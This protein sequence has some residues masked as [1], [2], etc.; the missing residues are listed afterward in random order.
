MLESMA[1]REPG[2]A[3]VTLPT[4]TAAAAQPQPSA[5]A[6][7][8]T[9][10]MKPA[11]AAAQLGQDARFEITA[12]GVKDLYGAIM[13]LSYDPRVVE[14]KTASEGTLLKQD[15]QQTSFLFSNNIKAGTVDIYMTRIG[16]VGGVAG[17]GALCTLIF[18]GKAGGT[19]D[20]TVKS[21]KL[22][23]FHRE[24]IRADAR[25]ARIAVK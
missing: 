14:F 4:P 8:V 10:E 21:V 13:T 16:D 11:D 5:T 1:K 20:L 6:G 7:A 9:L 12:A 24:Q 18:Q 19:T 25:G 22:T 3:P 15:G 2:A 23:N 17:S